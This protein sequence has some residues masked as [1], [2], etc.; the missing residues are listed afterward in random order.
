MRANPVLMIRYFSLQIWKH[1]GVFKSGVSWIFGRKGRVQF[2]TRRWILFELHLSQKWRCEKYDY[3][4]QNGFSCLYCSNQYCW[5]LIFWSDI[6]IFFYIEGFWRLTSE[7]LNVLNFYE[8]VNIAMNYWY[9]W[10]LNDFVFS[11]SFN[12]F[13][14]RYEWGGQALINIAF[15]Y[16]VE[17]RTPF[18]NSVTLFP[19][20]TMYW[21]INYVVCT[22]NRR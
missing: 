7:K 13:Y 21:T 15:C 14:Y 4:Y 1:L 5:I 20:C 18:S 9:T 8:I 2:S 16:S 12:G 19:C 11:L 17:N 22:I 6:I 10:P 3:T